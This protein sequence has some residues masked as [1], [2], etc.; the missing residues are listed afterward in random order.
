MTISVHIACDEPM[1]RHSIAGLLAGD[2]SIDV[3][4]ATPEGEKGVDT[5]QRTRPDVLV[6]AVSP[7]E[8][9]CRHARLYLESLPGHTGVVG[10]CTQDSQDEE[11]RK[12]GIVELVYPSDP[13]QVLRDA[14]RSMARTG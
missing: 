1:Y 9:V 14:V 11:Y 3:V 8:D 6:L 10:F 4:D 7:E 13:A 5:V 2:K 12:A